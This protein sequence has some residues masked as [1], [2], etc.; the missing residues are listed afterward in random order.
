[1]AQAQ[2]MVVGLE[3]NHHVIL[4]V[5][6]SNYLRRYGVELNEKSRAE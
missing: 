6:G 2:K 3:N 4:E 1:M 5:L